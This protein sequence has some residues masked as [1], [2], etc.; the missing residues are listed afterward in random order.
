[1]SIFHKV[2]KSI[3][4]VLGYLSWASDKLGNFNIS[5]HLNFYPM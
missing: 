1:M 2:Q 4:E 5:E 3:I